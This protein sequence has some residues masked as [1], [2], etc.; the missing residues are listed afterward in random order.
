M[1]LHHPQSQIHEICSIFP[2]NSFKIPSSKNTQNQL[3]A[4]IW[5]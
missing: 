2:Q 5:K 4:N 1:D 3:C